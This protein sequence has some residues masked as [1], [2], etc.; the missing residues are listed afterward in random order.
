M[1]ITAKERLQRVAD[2]K[3]Q[4]A[5]AVERGKAFLMGTDEAEKISVHDSEEAEQHADS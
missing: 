3:Q 1:N 2:A 5:D 4:R